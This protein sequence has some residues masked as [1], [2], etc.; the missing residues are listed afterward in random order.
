MVASFPR[1]FYSANL[2]FLQQEVEFS[3]LSVKSGGSLLSTVATHNSQTLTYWAD[4]SERTEALWEQV[5]HLCCSLPGLQQ[6]TQDAQCYRGSVKVRGSQSLS[7][8]TSGLPCTEWSKGGALV[9][10]TCNGIW[11]L[12][13]QSWGNNLELISFWLLSW[14]VLF[15]TFYWN[16]KMYYKLY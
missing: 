12:Q 11:H 14:P 9:L 5:V 6:L 7:A 1:A 15:R 3:F 13:F 10:A 2:S 16:D 8:Q 4:T